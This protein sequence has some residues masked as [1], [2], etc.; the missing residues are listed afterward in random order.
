[1]PI[2]YKVD[3]DIFKSKADAITNTVNCVGIMGKGLAKEF[4][5]RFPE[6]YK[7]YRK[8]CEKNQLKIG[9]LHVF[10]TLNRLII[11]FPTKQHWKHNS[12]L[13]WIEAGLKYF[14]KKYKKW[15]ITSVAFPQLGTSHGKLNWNDV[16]P[17]MEKYLNSL[18]IN[19]EIYVRS[20]DRSFQNN[21]FQQF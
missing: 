17:L 21:F 18:D 8:K 16:K 4:K 15:H 2:E 5:M 12:K 13:D 14:V 6:M 7:D 20:D 11:N 9:K 10:K 3:Q 1:M 19:V